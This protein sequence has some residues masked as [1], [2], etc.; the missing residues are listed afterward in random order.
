MQPFSKFGL[1]ARRYL[2]GFNG[3]AR[4]SCVL[5]GFICAVISISERAEAHGCADGDAYFGAWNSLKSGGGGLY[6]FAF[7]LTVPP[8]QGHAYELELVGRQVLTGG[9]FGSWSTSA[10]PAKMP[11]RVYFLWACQQEANAS[12]AS[13]CLLDCWLSTEDSFYDSAGGYSYTIPLSWLKG[14]IDSDTVPNLYDVDSALECDGDIFE[15]SGC[16]EFATAPVSSGTATPVEDTP[17]PTEL[18][19]AGGREDFY[20][21]GP[22]TMVTPMASQPVSGMPNAYGTI[23]L[24]N[25]AIR[26]LCFKGGTFNSSGA[27]TW[28]PMGG[29]FGAPSADK[30]YLG[31]YNLLRAGD[32]SAESAYFSA[33]YG[34]R[35]ANSL[36][37]TATSAVPASSFMTAFN[38]DDGGAYYWH[39]YVVIG[40]W[41]QIQ[42]WDGSCWYTCGLQHLTGTGTGGGPNSAG[43]SQYMLPAD[44]LHFYIPQGF[45]PG[46]VLGDTFSNV[47]EGVGSYP[48]MNGSL[49]SYPYNATTSTAGGSSG[50]SLS[51]SDLEQAFGNALRSAGVGQSSGEGG[52]LSGD[53]AGD[54]GAE[55][56]GS[57]GVGDAGVSTGI[58]EGMAESQDELFEGLTDVMGLDSVSPASNVAAVVGISLPKPGGGTFDVSLSTLPDT[59]TAAGL[60]LDTIRLLIRSGI[61]VFWTWKLCL[62]CIRMY[63]EIT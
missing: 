41:F 45:L 5:L 4:A 35:I 32:G 23:A 37:R 31:A 34:K 30:P 25:Q 18:T 55:A 16:T 13:A 59:S 12:A 28:G 19:M 43:K 61:L 1:S 60:A 3:S 40:G 22:S 42:Y 27:G 49:T 58:E 52:G 50:E 57:W 29:L 44:Q 7:R 14:D 51:V 2:S 46:D 24:A 17:V 47:A 11:T 36:P 6:Q 39:R 9:T 20:A 8:A 10:A 62:A 26:D 53:G 21:C 48:V 33:C 38:Y 54:A 56:F 63:R 15:K